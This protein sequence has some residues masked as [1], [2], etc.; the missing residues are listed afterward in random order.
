MRS[1]DG[2]EA[3]APADPSFS[4]AIHEQVQRRL[5]CARRAAGRGPRDARAI[6]AGP[7]RQPPQAA[8][9]VRSVAQC[10]RPRQPD[11]PG[12][13]RARQ[14]GGRAADRGAPA[15]G[16]GRLFVEGAPL[17]R[18]PRA[19]AL[20]RPRPAGR[21]AVRIAAVRP[22]FGNREQSHDR[23]GGNRRVRPRPLRDARARTATDRRQGPRAAAAAPREQIGGGNRSGR[24]RR[25]ATLRRPP[26]VAHRSTSK[27]Q[28]SRAAA[29][30]GPASI[31]TRRPAWP[32]ARARLA[33]A[34]T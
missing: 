23:R 25:A 5:H 14:D 29:A 22:A 9:A 19:R 33:T 24:R 15:E 30:D 11:R 34:A 17:C 2:P 7:G 26:A 32:R 21:R 13:G 6:S 20:L 3:A 16:V 18:R 4:G 28:A 12:A 1:N 8:Q 10:G 31:A 27:P